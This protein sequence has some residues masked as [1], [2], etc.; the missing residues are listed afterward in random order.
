MSA[1]SYVKFRKGT[2]EEFNKLDFNELKMDTLYF[3]YSPS[4]NV[5]Q[6][7]LGNK[8]IAG[9][10][11]PGS[12]VSTLEDLSNVFVE[13][14]QGKDLL[15][16]D[17]DQQKWVNQSLEEVLA[18]IN[19]RYENIVITIE[20]LNN[21]D[22]I[23][24]IEEEYYGRGS[25]KK[26]GDIV[27]IKDIIAQD[28]E[29]NKYQHTSYVFD[30]SN[31]TAMDGNY[32]AENIYFDENF[33][34]TKEIGAIEIPESGSLEVESQGKN[35]K[36]FLASIFA[37][38]EN[39]IT[40]NPTMSLSLT[41][42]T[43]SKYELGTVVNP[44]Y[45]ITFNHGKYSYG[46]LTGVS[47]SFEV[48]HSFGGEKLTDRKGTF[49]NIAINEQPFTIYATA[50]YSDG[51]IPVTNLSNPYP[52]GQILAGT[53][54][55]SKTISGYRC[56][57]Y[58]AVDEIIS[59]DQFNSNVIRNLNKIEYSGKNQKFSIDITPSTRQ[60]IIAYPFENESDT[61]AEIKDVNGMGANINSSFKRVGVEED[62]DQ[63]QT[64]KV[65]G[66][67]EYKPIKY[68]VFVYNYAADAV[69]VNNRYDITI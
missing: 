53:L 23:D 56:C 35:L 33:I 40:T 31:W 13:N 27:I 42:G 24:L 12:S 51:A 63:I 3:V 6:L 8:L 43:L 62:S 26:I 50:N 4:E 7:Y 52:E 55:D 44:V 49:N 37:K 45:N 28:D 22:H 25:A 21:N 60:I 64:V 11:A 9:G 19:T 58:G 17:E 5:G 30:G 38:E 2:F 32:S 66:E 15:V 68:N 20:N 46:P 41:D 47:F 59:E 54:T 48:S 39:P 67:N 16:Y 65:A 1:L 34:F 36:E 69:I 14:V 29:E 10:G 57:F 61:I 18:N